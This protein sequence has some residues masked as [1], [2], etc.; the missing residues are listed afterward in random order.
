MSADLAEQPVEPLVLRIAD[1]QHHR[2]EVDCQPLGSLVAVAS[3]SVRELQ[4]FR[5]VWSTTASPIPSPVLIAIAVGVIY[6]FVVGLIA[7][8]GTR[9]M[10]PAVAFLA[11]LFAYRIYFIPAINYYEWYLPPFLAVLMIV[12]ALGMQRMSLTLPVPP[13]GV[14]GRPR[15][16]V[17]YPHAKE[18]CGRPSDARD[19]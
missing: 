2:R 1:P 7:V 9:D 17:R 18:L 12:V 15:R 8:R 19:R 4:P 3:S 11:L 13:K 16:C 10:W 6:F 14:G 5:D